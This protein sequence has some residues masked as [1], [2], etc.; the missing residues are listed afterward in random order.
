MVFDAKWY[1]CIHD[2]RELNIPSTPACVPG[3]YERYE[4][5][6]ESENIDEAVT[7]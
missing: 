5:D 7:R 4:R 6:K 2:C 1:D 3:Y